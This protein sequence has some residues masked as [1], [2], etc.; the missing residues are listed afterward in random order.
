MNLLIEELSMNLN[1]CINQLAIVSRA[2]ASTQ[3]TSNNLNYIIVGLVVVIVI[4]VIA[5]M[6]GNSK[7]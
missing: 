4:L 3:T 6:K 7:K 1:S 2:I 5:T